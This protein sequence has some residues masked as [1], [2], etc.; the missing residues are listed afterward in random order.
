MYQAL[1]DDLIEEWEADQLL[2]DSLT[3]SVPRS[4]IERR[5]KVTAITHDQ[6]PKA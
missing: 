2:N 1:S 5:D 6:R 4:L 3:T